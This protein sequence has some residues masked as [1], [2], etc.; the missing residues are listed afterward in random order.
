[1][2][3]QAVWQSTSSVQAKAVCKQCAST[4]VECGGCVLSCVQCGSSSGVVVC[5]V[6][7][8]WCSRR[9]SLPSWKLA[10]SRQLQQQQLPTT[11]PVYHCPRNTQL[12][13]PQLC[14]IQRSTTCLSTTMILYAEYTAV[15]T[16][17]LPDTIVHNI[18]TVHSNNI[19]CCKHNCPHHNQ[20]NCPQYLCR[21]HNTIVC[22]SNTLKV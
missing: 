9:D 20:Y 21:H 14:P 16:T 18:Y 6:W 13:A 17:T 7:Q 19:I 8:Q 12:S 5:T 4:S 2:Q 3:A 1:M 22:S 11:R 15:R 10:A